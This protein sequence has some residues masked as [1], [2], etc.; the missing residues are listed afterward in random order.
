MELAYVGTTVDRTL[1]ATADTDYP[2]LAVTFD[3][4]SGAYIVEIKLMAAAYAGSTLTNLV[5]SLTDPGNALQAFDWASARANSDLARLH[6]V[7]RFA[8]STGTKTYKARY[9]SGNASGF[10]LTHYGSESFIRAYSL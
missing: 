7:K 5:L 10:Y 8:P 9:R 3:A 1:N 2:G 4:P 6:I